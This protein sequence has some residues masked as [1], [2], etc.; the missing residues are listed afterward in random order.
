MRCSARCWDCALTRG[1]CGI[2]VLAVDATKMSANA[3]ARATRDYQ[4]IAREILEPVAE[5]DAREDEQ[6][7]DA[8][9]DELP[10]A[11]ATREGRLTSPISTHAMSRR[12]A[13]G[14][15]ATTPKRSAPRIRS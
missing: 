13:V 1:C 8:R 6:F 15:R 9:G 2:G 7:G 3:S 10:P 5:I 4:Q 12:C 11:L 14:C